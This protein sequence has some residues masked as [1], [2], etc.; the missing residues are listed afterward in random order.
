MAFLIP[1]LDQRYEV[2]PLWEQ[3]GQSKLAE[4]TTLVI[5]GD[6]HLEP[7]LLEAMPRLG[8]IACFSVGYDGVD[9]E[10]ARTHGIAVSHAHG[11]NNEDVADHA[12]GLIIGQRRRIVD[13]DRMLRAGDWSTRSTGITP[14]LGGNTIGIVGMGSIGSAIA[15]RAEAMLMQVRW[16]GPSPK[17]DIAWPRE[18]SLIALAM[19]SDILVVA[20]R[21]HADNEK[22]IS[23]EV[24]DALGPNGL[25]VNV[26]RGQLVDE[27]ALIAAL[28]EKRLG[29]AALDVY[30]QEPA[31]AERWTNVPNTVLTPHMAGATDNA[32][33]R[34]TRMLLANIDAFHAGT[35]LPTPVP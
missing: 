25:L 23:A 16:W 22:M 2:L 21:A 35:P 1:V 27:D 34:M 17:A 29:G 28:C 20:A 8:L 26:A 19:A 11:A 24:I 7:A 3:S 30:A 9:L 15:R 13:G 33:E 31:P 12:I 5:A 6:Y 32:G 18:E 4:A 14:S 10:W